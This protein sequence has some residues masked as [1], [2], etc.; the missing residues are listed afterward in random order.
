MTN[1]LRDLLEAIKAKLG[2]KDP[3]TLE[4]VVRVTMD[5]TALQARSLAGENVQGEI[6]ILQA[7]AANLDEHA[8][9]VIGQALLAFCTQ[10]LGK[11]L[12]VAIAAA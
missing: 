11:A 3:A 4:L 6:A 7:T 1:D 10:L 9:T 12:G 2:A 8:R 5:A